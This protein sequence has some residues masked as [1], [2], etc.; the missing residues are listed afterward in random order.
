VH[1]VVCPLLTLLVFYYFT[2]FDFDRNSATTLYF[3]ILI[4]ISTNFL[5]LVLFSECWLVTSIVFGVAHVVFQYRLGVEMLGES[6]GELAIKSAYV[7][8]IYALIGYITE[9]NRKEAHLG[10]NARSKAFLRWMRVFDTFPEGVAF[11]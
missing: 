1:Q 11:I 7:I 9:R 3:L 10:E 6:L 2:Y 5:L 4:E 8:L